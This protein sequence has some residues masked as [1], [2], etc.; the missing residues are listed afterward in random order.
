MKHS[1]RLQKLQSKEKRLPFHRKIVVEGKTYWWKVIGHGEGI[2][3]CDS[4]RKPFLDEFWGYE[5][6]CR[7]QY[8]AEKILKKLQG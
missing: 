3:I 1:L 7:P 2:S 4:D 5:A 8:V 6:T